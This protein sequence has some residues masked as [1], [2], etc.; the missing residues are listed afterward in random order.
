[1]RAERRGPRGGLRHRE[2]L[3]ADGQRRLRRHGRGRRRRPAGRLAGPAAPRGQAEPRG[4]QRRRP[5]PRAS[6]APLT[7]MPETEHPAGQP[8]SV[9]KLTDILRQG[10]YLADRGLAT[11]LFV[12]MSLQRPILLE[13]EVGVG[14]TEVA[15]VL[16]S[17]F[18]R[19]LIRLQCY[20]G[21]DSNQAMYEW[22]Y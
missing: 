11:A 19:K 20:E 22:D 3:Q 2:V 4:R 10:G 16:A 17:V 21:I 18:G 12:A 8:E 14:K 6:G 15:K 5:C 7:Q 9:G 13:G 1:T